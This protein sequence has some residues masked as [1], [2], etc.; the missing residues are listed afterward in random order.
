ME[1]IEERALKKRKE[2]EQKDGRSLG[3]DGIEKGYILGATEQKQIDK[4][5]ALDAFDMFIDYLR[6]RGSLNLEDTED[7]EFWKSKFV[8]LIK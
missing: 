3:S 8:E 6:D 2:Y 5:K 4:E 1:S 7:R